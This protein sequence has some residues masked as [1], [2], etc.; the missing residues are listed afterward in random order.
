MA[1]TIH[2][3]EIE[4]PMTINGVR[5]QMAM[6]HGIFYGCAGWDEVAPSRNDRIVMARIAEAVVRHTR[7][8]A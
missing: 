4:L 6:A 5:C 3:S 2:F 7:S 1:S 8:L